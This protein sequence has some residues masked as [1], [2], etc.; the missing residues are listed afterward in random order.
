M[1]N[2]STN[3]P[4][5]AIRLDK[6]TTLIAYV[7]RLYNDHVAAE[8]L[9]HE[10]RE[11]LR[12]FIIERSNAAKDIVKMVT[13]TGKFLEELNIYEKEYVEERVFQF[14]YTQKIYQAIFEEVTTAFLHDLQRQGGDDLQHLQENLVYYYDL[15]EEAFRVSEC[16]E[17]NFDGFEEI[18]ASVSAILQKNGDNN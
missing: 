9:I 3:V 7:S 8:L 17:E 15:F 10:F 13:A 4:F 1:E 6:E 5:K 2:L 14:L 16:V 11:E 18:R 12:Q